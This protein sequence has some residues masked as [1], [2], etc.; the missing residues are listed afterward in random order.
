MR[1]LAVAIACWIALFPAAGSAALHVPI[2]VEQVLPD[3]A[4]EHPIPGEPVS[5]GVPLA[6]A[7]GVDDVR[8]LGLSGTSAAQFRVLQ[9]DP[10]SG[11]ATWVLATFIADGGPY[12]LVPG[13]GA[14][15]GCCGVS[16]AH[17]GAYM[18]R[19]SR[20]LWTGE[21]I[22]NL[23]SVEFYLAQQRRSES[24]SI[25]VRVSGASCSTA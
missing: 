15:G 24:L 2:L 1:S 17:G 20:S 9:R 18:D 12:A 21:L 13:S 5:A 7:D 14:S 10:E 25:A 16:R 22:T 8:S 3:G 11:R 19:L 6:V 4:A 23:L